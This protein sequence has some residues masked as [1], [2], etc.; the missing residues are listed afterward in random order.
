MKVELRTPTGGDIGI[1]TNVRTINL[2]LDSLV[3]SVTR[4][5]ADKVV[6]ESN[7]LYPYRALLDTLLNYEADVMKTRLKCEGY[8]EDVSLADTN[9]ATAGANT[10]VKAR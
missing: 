3:Q 10:G 8:E 4:K 5:I 6:S 9:P 1:G 7:N 2:P